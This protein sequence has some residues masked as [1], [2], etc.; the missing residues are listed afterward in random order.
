MK[1]LT[2][3]G[4]W[5]KWCKEVYRRSLTQAKAYMRVARDKDKL[6]LRRSEDL[7]LNE[8][9]RRLS[10]PKEEKPEESESSL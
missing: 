2:P 4:K 5:E 8:A 6:N 10:P 1:Q 7:S 3:H 9:L